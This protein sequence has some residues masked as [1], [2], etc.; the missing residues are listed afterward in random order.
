VG[1]DLDSGGCAEPDGRDLNPG[2]DEH[3]L[4]HRQLHARGQDHQAWGNKLLL[5]CQVN[6]SG[7]SVLR[8]WSRSRKEPHL[9]VGAG[10]GA[11]TRCSSGSNGSDN[12]IKHG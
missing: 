7:Q 6:G 8:S 11:V 2:H 9:L 4:C 1:V 3:S 12:G 5:R 10:A